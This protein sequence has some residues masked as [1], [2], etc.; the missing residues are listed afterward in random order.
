MKNKII[1]KLFSSYVLLALGIMILSL[2][3]IGPIGVYNYL[4]IKKKWEIQQRFPDFLVEVGDS[5][6]TGMTIFDAIKVASK[7]HYGR[8]T[9][10]I[11]R[12]KAQL[13]WDLSMRDVFNNFAERM[14]S[15]IVQ[16][17]VLTVNRGL[18]M[19]GN[20][21]RIFKSAAREVFQVN[22]LENQRRTNMAVYT[23]V[24]FVCFFVFL[25]IIVILN[26]T[27]FTSFFE[28][29]ETQT[30][31]M[32][33]FTLSLF[34]PMVLK[35]AMYLFVFVQSLGAGVLGG[36]MIDGKLSS[37]IRYSCIL[38]LISFFIFKFLF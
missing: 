18:D 25:A 12:M 17:V 8:L 36:F 3:L 29:Q 4:E 2:F 6:N 19:G 37:G 34:D 26:R 30:L 24:I 33:S 32:G 15:A 21:P 11:N 10:E 13:S 7:A 28:L 5:L 14:K 27:I 31:R 20:T 38:G 23:L 1:Q 22:R 9:S 16:R 35:Y